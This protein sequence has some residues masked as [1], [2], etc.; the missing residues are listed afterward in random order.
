MVTTISSENL[1]RPFAFYNEALDNSTKIHRVDLYFDDDTNLARI[2]YP[3]GPWTIE[4]QIGDFEGKTVNHLIYQMTKGYSLNYSF[5]EPL[6]AT[7][8][9]VFSVKLSKVSEGGLFKPGLSH[10]VLVEKINKDWKPVRLLSALESYAHRD[11][12]R[13]DDLFR[14]ALN[15]QFYEQQENVFSPISQPFKVS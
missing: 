5:E 4:S 14:T 10:L 7:L 11:A 12:Y 13:N 9:D 1:V 3:F 8:G 6:I 2:L 15:V